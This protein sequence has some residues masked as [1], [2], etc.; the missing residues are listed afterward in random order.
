MPVSYGEQCA[1]YLYY[2]QGPFVAAFAQSNE[3]DVSPNTKGPHCLDSGIPCDILHS[4]CHGKVMGRV[5]PG[6]WVGLCTIVGGAM[7]DCG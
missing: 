2:A 7:Y 1:L 6:G 4:T 3:G 5:G